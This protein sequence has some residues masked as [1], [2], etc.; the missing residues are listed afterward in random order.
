MDLVFILF[1]IFVTC[2]VLYVE[3]T[4]SPEQEAAWKPYLDESE[5]SG[6]ILVNKTVTCLY[7]M[8]VGEVIMCSELA[9][10]LGLT[11]KEAM[12]LL[13]DALSEKVVEPVYR[14]GTTEKIRGYDNSV[15]TTKLSNLAQ[16]FTLSNGQKLD[17]RDPHNIVVGFMRS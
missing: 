14:L 12:D 15:W 13:S 6:P 5:T 8:R 16:V 4:L 1:L 7:S 3:W 9:S 2:V 11:A 17:G 10:K